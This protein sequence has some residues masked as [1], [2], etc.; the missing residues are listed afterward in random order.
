MGQQCDRIAEGFRTLG[1]TVSSNM[2]EADLAYG[3]DSGAY[4][5]IIEAKQRGIIRGKVV[6][7]CLDLAPHLGAAFPLARIKEQLTHA[8]AVTTISQT[9]ASDIKARLGIDATV[10]Y[11]PIR[12]VARARDV[13]LYKGLFV[14]RVSDPEKR[15]A[16]GATALSILGYGWNDM[17][18]VGREP[19]P[20]GGAYYGEA[21]DAELSG[22]YNTSTFLICPTRNA[23]LGLPILEAMACGC[24]PVVCNDLD[25]RAEFLPADV[26]PEYTATEPNAP[27]LARFIARYAQDEEARTELSNRLYGHYVR[28]WA[29]KLSPAGVAGAIEAVYEGLR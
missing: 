9:V 18:T 23:F 1:W 13:V 21:T 5:Q 15:A 12:N 7:T 20:Y 25:V 10:V 27:S 19:P 4:P 3:N 17:V 16:L 28:E 11:N 8:D 29:F 2:G 14:G 6:F 26:F 24:I 22:F